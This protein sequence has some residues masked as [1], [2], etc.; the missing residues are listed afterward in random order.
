MREV[1][2][3]GV[4][5]HPFG[6]FPEKRFQ[7]MTRQAITESLKD[8]GVAWKQIQAAYCG[9][10]TLSVAG[11]RVLH[12]V[13]LIGIP[14]VNVDNACATA[15]S[16]F[17]LA[18]Q[19]I[20]TGIYDIAIAFGVEKMPKGFIATDTYTMEPRQYVGAT[21]PF[22]WALAFRRHQA[23]YGTTEKQLGIVSVKNHK[24]AVHNPNAMYRTEMSLEEVMN[25]AV[26]CDP[27]RLFML[28]APNDGAAAAILCSADK[29]RQFTGKPIKIAACVLGCGRYGG[30]MPAIPDFSCSAKIEVPSVTEFTSKEAYRISGIGPEDLDMAEI[31]DT[32]SWNEIEYM[33]QLGFCK[34]GE[35]GPMIEQGKTLPGS[36]LPINVSGG[37]LSKG[38]P[39]GASALGQVHEVVLHLRGQAGARQVPNAKVGLTHV[40]G[41][42]DNSCVMIL[43]K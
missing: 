14:I 38:E 39:V 9:C 37:L 35:A 27:L 6:R 10:Y 28:C 2:I 26:V 15:G 16:A 3:I 19:A 43:K 5:I 30:P 22:Y 33:E 12:E 34:P 42:A 25:S 11:H 8:A 23:K 18:Y 13:G 29:A 32:C 24:N 21:N 31:Q 1:A 17:R 40:Y 7:D 36:K 20:A 41:G 4:G